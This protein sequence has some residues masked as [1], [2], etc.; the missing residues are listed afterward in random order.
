MLPPIFGLIFAFKETSEEAEVRHGNRNRIVDEMH[1]LSCFKAKSA[2]G[3][4]K[5][6]I[7]AAFAFNCVK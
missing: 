5:A 2:E 3:Q 4:L 1:D 7:K 6:N